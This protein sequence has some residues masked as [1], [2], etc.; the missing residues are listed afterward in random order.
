MQENLTIKTAGAMEIQLAIAGAGSR[1]Y[2]FIIDWHIRLLLALA[3]FYLVVLFMKLVG[4]FIT[5]S[6]YSSGGLTVLG[7]IGLLPALIIYFLYHPVLECVTQGRTPGKRMAGIRVVDKEGRTPTLGALCVRNIFR[8]VDSLPAYYVLGLI[9]VFVTAKQVRIGDIAAGTLLVYEEKAKAGDLSV[10]AQM[11]ETTGL[12]P[13][14]IEILQEMLDRWGSMNRD[15]RVDLA[16]RYLARLGH[17]IPSGMRPAELDMRL[18]A[19]L[20]GLQRGD[21]PPIDSAQQPTA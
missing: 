20:L 16:K 3:W 11:T 17:D 12:N 6:V 19:M 14:Q 5:T 9:V 13:E 10:L 7:Y 15:S 1:S 8:I 2:A 4:S 21:G 18:H